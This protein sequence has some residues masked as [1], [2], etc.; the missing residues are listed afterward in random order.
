MIKISEEQTPPKE[1]EK[2]EE[3]Q[4]SPLIESANAAADRLLAQNERLE[5]NMAK[6]ETLM[7]TQALAGKASTGEKAKEETDADYAK[8]VLAGENGN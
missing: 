3:P 6:H 8:K 5:R 7:A 1:E 4:T 2:E